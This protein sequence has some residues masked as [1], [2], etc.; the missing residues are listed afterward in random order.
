M[1]AS[2]ATQEATWLRYPASDLG[3]GDLRIQEFGTLCE[4]DFVKVQLSNK[5]RTDERPVTIFEDNKAAIQLS[6]NPVLHKRSRHIHVKYHYTRDQYNKGHIQLTYINTTEN[7]ADIMTKVLPR[8]T[9]S[10]LSGKLLHSV[11]D[12]VVYSFDGSPMKG[13]VAPVVKDEL[14]FVDLSTYWK[15]EPKDISDFDQE[16]DIDK[17]LG[18]KSRSRQ[19]TE[20]S[21]SG[22]LS[23]A[24]RAYCADILRRQALHL[25]GRITYG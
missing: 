19:S 22:G 6:K 14:N 10:Y 17:H 20:P 24:V 21:M 1:A 15:V 25:A 9:H 18:H 2:L 5:V 8:A 11:I 23:I 4:K 3:Y 13:D 7:I 12:G 16:C